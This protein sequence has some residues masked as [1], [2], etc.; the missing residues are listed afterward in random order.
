MVKDT[1]GHNV[2]LTASVVVESTKMERNKQKKKERKKNR[3]NLV[4]SLPCL[5]FSFLF[6]FLCACFLEEKKKRP[7]QQIRGVR[8][9]LLASSTDVSD[10]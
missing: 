9:V 6:P 7:V 4:G 5:T 2:H 3:R 10:V 1:Q 8:R